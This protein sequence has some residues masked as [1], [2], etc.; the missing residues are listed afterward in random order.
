MSGPL[1]RRSFTLLSLIIM[2]QLCACSASDNDPQEPAHATCGNGIIEEEERCDGVELNGSSCQQQGYFSG[3]LRCNNSCDY[4][5]S[6]CVNRSEASCGDGIREAEEV[7]DGQDIGDVAACSNGARPVCDASCTLQCPKAPNLIAPST[8]NFGLVPRGS[9]HSRYI[10]LENRGDLKLDL[11]A[12]R[13]DHPNFTINAVAPT[14]WPQLDPDERLSVEITFSPTTNDPISS[15]LTIQSND[16][17]TPSHV[18]DLYANQPL[19][20]LI[21]AEANMPQRPTTEAAH[22]MDFG[23]VHQG[24]TSSKDLIIQNCGDRPLSLK[25]LERSHLSHEAFEIAIPSTP[26]RIEAH[27]EIKL[28]VNYTPQQPGEAKGQLQLALDEPGA[29]QLQVFLTGHAVADSCPIAYA[30]GRRQNSQGAPGTE[31]HAPNL[32]II[33]LNGLESTAPNGAIERFEWNIIK[34]PVNSVTR[35][36]PSAKSPQPQL[37]MDLPGEYIIEL[38]VYDQRGIPSCKPARVTMLTNLS[39]QVQIELI[40]SSPTTDVELHY[41]RRLP[42]STSPWS[43]AP[44]DIF[45]SNPTADWGRLGAS[46]DPMMTI[47]QGRQTLRHDKPDPAEVY[48]IGVRYSKRSAE[49]AAAPQEVSI[50]VI[51]EGVPSYTVQ[52]F[53]LP[54]QDGFWHI[55][56]LTNGYNFR[57]IDTLSESPP[58]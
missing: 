40:S 12:L 11:T 18:I 51:I 15:K 25:Q 44:H 9:H 21:I 32:S 29:P 57:R 24:A 14:G 19:P 5:A 38:T 10:E 30:T 7:C 55:G 13:T 56:E 48:D 27:D 22:H 16:P 37:F 49:D 4:D 50:N 36:A 46:D 42:Y 33:A 34:S 1:K 54:D 26:L 52:S 31:I 2:L 58:N 45:W 53:Q 20:C 8:L 17:D 28:R 35:L 23:V 39:D 43:T 47:D 6:G 41:K 3:T